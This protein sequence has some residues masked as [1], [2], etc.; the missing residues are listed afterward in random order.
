MSAD[1]VHLHVHSH[2]SLLDGACTVKQLLEMTKEYDM[3]ACAITDHG[4]MGGVVDMYDTFK[5][6]GKKPIIGCEVYVSPTTRFDRDANKPHIRGHHLVLLAENIQGYHSLCKLLSEAWLNGMYYKPRVDRD[7]LREHHEGLI[8][9]SADH[10]R[11]AVCSTC[12]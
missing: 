11:Y 12:R 4:Y 2:Y 1:F 10:G 8:A 5:A 3:P 7:L 9:L 6:G